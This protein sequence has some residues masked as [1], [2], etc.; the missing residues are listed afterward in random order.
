MISV[1][2]RSVSPTDSVLLAD[3]V[4]GSVTAEFKGPH[5]VT[6]HSAL[7]EEDKDDGGPGTGPT[8]R[9]HL[10]RKKINVR[11]MTAM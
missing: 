4:R 6:S 5:V 1:Q 9:A 7:E 8:D 10:A 11:L 3:S 2:S